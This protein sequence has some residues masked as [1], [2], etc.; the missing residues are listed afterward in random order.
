MSIEE[1]INVKRDDISEETVMKINHLLASYKIEI[2]RILSQK[3]H[4]QAKEPVMQPHQDDPITKSENDPSENEDLLQPFNLFTLKER[5]DLKIN[6][7]HTRFEK[8]A[9]NNTNADTSGGRKKKHFGKTSKIDGVA[10]EHS[11]CDLSKLPVIPT[12]SQT[13]SLTEISSRPPRPLSMEASRKQVTFPKL[14]QKYNILTTDWPLT[15]FAKTVDEVKTNH[16]TLNVQP[17]PPKS[18]RIKHINELIDDSTGY[19]DVVHAPKLHSEKL[20]IVD[21]RKDKISI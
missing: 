19:S 13:S 7:N 18:M 6:L 17:S 3:P 11:S 20:N 4:G 10:Q 21:H 8:T 9:P 16:S 2:S 15:V 5:A 12:L 1:D 14:T